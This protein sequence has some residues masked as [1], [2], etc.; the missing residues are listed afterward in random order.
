MARYL[1][2]HQPLAA[3]SDSQ[4]P[5]AS[6]ASGAPPDSSQESQ[7]QP[8]LNAKRP[9]KRRATSL[10]LVDR[11]MKRSFE[12]FLNFNTTHFLHEIVF[13]VVTPRQDWIYFSHTLLA[14]YRSQPILAV[15]LLQLRQEMRK[16]CDGVDASELPSEPPLILV[17][18]DPTVP[19]PEEFKGI[20][21]AKGTKRTQ[22][23]RA[24]KKALT[25]EPQSEEA[26]TAS[27]S[28]SAAAPH[29]HNQQPE[30]NI[31]SNSNND[32]ESDSDTDGD[33]ATASADE[34]LSVNSNSS[35]G[36]NLQHYNTQNKFIHRVDRSFSRRSDC[37]HLIGYRT[38]NPNSIAP[39]MSLM[40]PAK[41]ES[42]LL[43]T[44]R[45]EFLQM[46]FQYAGVSGSGSSVAA[47]VSSPRLEPAASAINSTAAAAVRLAFVFPFF[48]HQSAI[49]FRRI[50][51]WTAHEL[52]RPLRH[53]PFGP[54][55][56]GNWTM[57]PMFADYMTGIAHNVHN[58][59]EWVHSGRAERAIGRPVR[60]KI[61]ICYDQSIAELDRAFADFLEREEKEVFRK[62]KSK[63]GSI[64]SRLESLGAGESS[65]HPES[66]LYS[67]LLS[68]LFYRT[69]LCSVELK[70]FS[71]SFAERVFG[72]HSLNRS[73]YD[74]QLQSSFAAAAPY[75]ISSAFLGTLYRYFE[76]FVIQSNTE[77][78]IFCRDADNVMKSGNG[79]HDL[80]VI[81]SWMKRFLDAAESKQE[82]SVNVG[83]F[84]AY[85][86]PTAAHYAQPLVGGSFGFHRSLFEKTGY[87]PAEFC[88]S[89]KEQILL[90]SL[91]ESDSSAY[92]VGTKPK[93]WL[94]GI[95]E[96]FLRNSLWKML[97]TA[98]KLHAR[99]PVLSSKIVEETKFHLPAQNGDRLP[100]GIGICRNLLT[101]NQLHDF[102][103]QMF[104][105][106]HNKRLKQKGLHELLDVFEVF[107]LRISLRQIY[108]GIIKKLDKLTGTD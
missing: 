56:D 100:G 52:D 46:L 66:R 83:V 25:A 6:P 50:R 93:S 29:D 32:P 77:D 27:R 28:E 67:S 85:R 14:Q 75:S 82:G 96:R 97:E 89:L 15:H 48:V 41:V 106:Y 1:Q 72:Q 79:T 26:T 98:E 11:V 71:T 19:L 49:E 62:S 45:K 78:F 9:R 74:E 108:S 7:A 104:I 20:K 16:R 13:L 61:V 8:K 103:I 59:F 95:D 64:K 18:D 99:R 47:S 24:K 36:I 10:R 34:S 87:S 81:S 80:R 40:L 91:A 33:V 101:F 43:E 5:S 35:A 23:F 107:E 102:S 21:E 3:S 84:H 42:D 73:I 22:K 53:H 38:N 54:D 86:E 55:F 51:L 30:E 63:K 94:Y 69:E 39:I 70:D 57:V 92:E 90:D 105:D 12:K 60:L 2:Q 17:T 76:S 4:A 65:P 31:N 44:Q 37:R 58:L 68:S 88:S